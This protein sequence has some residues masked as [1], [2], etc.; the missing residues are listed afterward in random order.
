LRAAV[1]IP[2]D[3]VGR[4]AA[5]LAFLA[6]AVRAIEQALRERDTYTGS[7]SMRV[8]RYATAIAQELRLTANEQL[9]IVLG[10]ELHDIGKIG[11]PDDLLRKHGRLSAEEMSQVKAHPIIG[12]RILRPLL[13]E[14]PTVMQIVRWH[15]ERIDGKGYPDGLS[16]DQIPLA[17]RIVAV[18]DAFDSMTSARPYRPAR[19]MADAIEE[20]RRVSGTQ[21][22]TDCV[23]AFL[24]ALR[25]DPTLRGVATLSQAGVRALALVLAT[26]LVVP[27]PSDAWRFGPRGPRPS[28]RG[29]PWRDQ[30]R[31]GALVRNRPVLARG[32]PA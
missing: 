24:R 32:E 20:L 19:T 4:P 26:H 29:P 12:E 1:R 2:G 5:T 27:E 23:R 3:S 17:A 18:A 7:H 8:S 30:V 16:G 13:K 22:D 10:A 9:G 11:L 6:D 14:H 15:H 31:T 28:E 21:L 25:R